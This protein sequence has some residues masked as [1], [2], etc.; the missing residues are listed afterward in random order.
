MPRPPNLENPVAVIRSRLGLKNQSFAEFLDYSAPMLKHVESGRK[1]ISD[2]LAEKIS[3]KTSVPL[4]LLY[5]RRLSQAELRS[6]AAMRLAPKEPEGSRTTVAKAV[7]ILP[8]L[9]ATT[10]LLHKATSLNSDV[11]TSVLT[12]ELAKVVVNFK[13]DIAELT[14]VSNAVREILNRGGEK[15][16]FWELTDAIHES[17]ELQ[18]LFGSDSLLSE[19]EA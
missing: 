5:K 16:L 3:S 1:P 9:I 13:L 14:A 18:K 6:I 10:L 19:E 8:E 17:D 11:V 2:E 4:A 12:R 15:A 7:G